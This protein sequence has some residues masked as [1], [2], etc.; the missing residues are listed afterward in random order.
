MAGSNSTLE[1]VTP[2]YIRQ[3]LNYNPGTGEF[4]WKERLS[5]RI[6]VGDKTGYLNKLGYTII[7]VNKENYPAHRLAWMHYY[8]EVPPSDVVHADGNRANNQIANLILA[9]EIQAA[10]NKGRVAWGKD[11]K[12][13]ITAERL[14]YLLSYDPETGEFTWRHSSPR[15]AAGS[16]AGAKRLSRTAYYMDVKLDGRHYGM[17]RLAWLYVHG[18]WPKGEIDHID[19]DGCNNRLV[20]LRDVSRHVNMQNQ[21]RAKGSTKSGLLGVTRDAGGYGWSATI[22]VDGKKRHL[23]FFKCKQEAHAAYVEAKRRLHEGCTI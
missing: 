15:A 11:G 14:R 2:S 12:Q 20:N 16:V 8:G 22:G 5:T 21:R 3:V 9:S 4:F 6:R 10:R 13:L 19:G 1:S 7:R 23:G 17:H 18:D